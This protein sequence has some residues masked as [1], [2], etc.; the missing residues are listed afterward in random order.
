VQK[1]HSGAPWFG[2]DRHHAAACSRPRER[3][4]RIRNKRAQVVM[5]PPGKHVRTH[6]RNRSVSLFTWLCA[7]SGL[8]ESSIPRDEKSAWTRTS[9]CER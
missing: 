4:M 7:V 2:S 8:P 6:A 9:K 3:R 5:D 1:L